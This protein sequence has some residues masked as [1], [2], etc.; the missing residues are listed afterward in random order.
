MRSSFNRASLQGVVVAVAAI[1]APAMANGQGANKQFEGVVTFESEG[2]RSFNYSIHKG[3]VRIDMN[4]DSRK[5]AMIVDPGAHK[6]YMLM[7]ERQM[8]MEMKVP[9][10]TQAAGDGSDAKP[11]RTGKSEVV[12]GHRC[13]YWSVEEEQGKVDICLA[14]DMGGFQAFS[15]HMIGS[16]SAWQEAIG[17]DAFPLKVI[18][19][20]DDNQDKVAL[21]ATKVEQK[22]LDAE[23]FTPPASYKK[24]EMNMK[25]PGSP[26]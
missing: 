9:E 10:D 4:D 16:A 20:G 21:V 25:M 15:N 26:R 7:P 1:L 11:T 6:M 22:S 12:A 23:L 24:M 8:Y 18:I 2:G 19:H 5:A 3:L 13:D 17:K 14:A